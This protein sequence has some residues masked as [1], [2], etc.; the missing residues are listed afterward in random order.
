MKPRR[1]PVTDLLRRARRRITDPARWC[2]RTYA[3]DAQGYGRRASDRTATRWC[4]VGALQAE[5]YHAAGLV[6][7]EAH[8]RLNGAAELPEAPNAEGV[9]IRYQRVEWV[10]DHLGHDAVLEVYDAAIREK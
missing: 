10:N 8:R 9:P 7:R 6:V 3:A 1:D 2:Q 5:S 4:A